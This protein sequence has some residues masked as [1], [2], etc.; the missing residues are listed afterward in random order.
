MDLVVETA[1]TEVIVRLSG[2]IDVADTPALKERLRAAM[3]TGLPVRV[4]GTG[5]TFLGSSGLTV[6]LELRR[7]GP[8]TLD[9]G[10]ERIDRLL[11]LTGGSRP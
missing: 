10:N 11:A 4:D 1:A 6:F 9:R 2:E 5:V 3:E 7:L 8:L